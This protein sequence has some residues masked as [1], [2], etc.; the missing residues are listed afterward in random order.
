[1][2]ETLL[3]LFYLHFTA[4][5]PQMTEPAYTAP[6]VMMEEYVPET[7]SV[8][9]PRRMPTRIRG[10]RPVEIRRKGYQPTG[11]NYF[12]KRLKHAVESQDPDLPTMGQ[13]Q[14]THRE[15]VQSNRRMQRMMRGYPRG[16]AF[17]CTE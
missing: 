16:C 11:K 5:S 3:P 15:S 4:P 17:P 6:P 8:P 13:S 2:L 9:L 12:T 10:E 14:R 1:M 7:T